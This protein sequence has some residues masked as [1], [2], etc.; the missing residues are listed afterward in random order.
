VS[1]NRA[2]PTLPAELA[3]VDADGT[4]SGQVSD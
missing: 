2:I 3:L 4:R 1:A